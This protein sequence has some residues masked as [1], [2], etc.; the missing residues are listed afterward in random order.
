MGEYHQITLNEWMDMKEKLRQELNNLRTAFVRV[1]YVLRRMEDTR[2]YEAEGYKSVAEFA[3]KEHG[4]KPSTTSRWMSINREYS[5]GGY[6]E[7]L[8][9]R[10]IGMN[11]SQLAEMLALPEKDREL[12]TPETPRADIRELK[13]FNKDAEEAERAGEAPMA[14]VKDQID[15]AFESLLEFDDKTR[16]RIREMLIFT[17]T[18]DDARVFEAVAPAG[19]RMHRAG[20]IFLTFNASG[21]GV[22]VFG[23]SQETVPWERFTRVAKDWMENHE[24]EADGAAG[25]EEK[26]ES[27]VPDEVPGGGEEGP[28]DQPAEDSGRAESGADEGG[29]PEPKAEAKEEF[30]MNPP[31]NVD[32]DEIAPAQLDE[33]EEPEP[34]EN[35]PESPAPEPQKPEIVDENGQPAP[36]PE[37]ERPA[38][39]VGKQLH[40][41]M[42]TLRKRLSKANMAM[43]R[44]ISRQ[45]WKRARKAGEEMVKVLKDIEDFVKA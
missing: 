17:D 32:S 18:P 43:D 19:A 3:E 16:A 4:L 45:D 40:D 38:A 2:A 41:Y 9:P 5:L 14:A 39:E 25:T 11:A 8:D 44:Y 24:E 35:E 31:E 21:I 6:S 13:R 20:R 26:A 28:A 7:T 23:G 37:E 33:E 27:A 1:G 36:D 29:E 34:A 15:E 30:G 12:I 10:Y 22:K 42:Q